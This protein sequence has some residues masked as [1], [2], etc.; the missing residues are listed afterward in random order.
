MKGTAVV[1]GPYAVIEEGAVLGSRVSIGAQVYIG[2]HVS[3][4]DDTVI[5]P[6][7][8]IYHD[9]EIGK[10][11]R[12]DT[13][14]AIGIE[15]FGFVQHEGSNVKVPQVGRV[16]IEDDVEF[17][18]LNSVAR[19][20]I[21]ETRIGAGTKID[22]LVHIAHNVIIGKNCVLVA[23]SGCAGNAVLGDNVILAGQVGVVDHATIG[24]NTV[25]MARGVVTKDIPAGSIVAGFP[26]RDHR[27]DKRTQVHVNKLGD[28][29]GRVKDLERRMP[30]A[31]A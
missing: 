16:V 15:G 12:I 8:M 3:I 28:L 9:T 4:G 22:C 20:T 10:R 6:Q 31:P 18:G 17:F 19:A 23:Q 21:G 11:V 7:V 30:G 14:A 2:K 1:V 25:V 27:E 26:A 13:G 29:F 5:A 24:S